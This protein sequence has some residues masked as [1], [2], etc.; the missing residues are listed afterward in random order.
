MKIILVTFSL[1]LSLNL[2]AQGPAINKDEVG[3]VLDNMVAQGVISAEQAA[4]AKQDMLK[5][6]NQDWNELTNKAHEVVNRDPEMK[7]KLKQTLNGQP[8]KFE[9]ADSYKDI[10]KTLD[11]QGIK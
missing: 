5:M 9:G 4:A 10:Q 11:A 7:A 6:G 3:M 8:P 1:M 2:F